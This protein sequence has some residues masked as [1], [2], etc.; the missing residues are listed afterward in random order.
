[1]H[2]ELNYKGRPWSINEERKLHYME[3]ARRVKEWR[4]TF[5]WLAKEAKIPPCTAITI[6][7]FPIQ[8]R[9]KLGDVLNNYPAAKA[10]IDGIVDAGVV[11]DDSPEY[12]RAITLHAP[13]RGENALRVV[14]HAV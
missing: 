8:Q 6:E 3:R 12:V 2:W 9:G 10:A 4:E 14:I 5:Y 11:P 13:T 7:A 1:M